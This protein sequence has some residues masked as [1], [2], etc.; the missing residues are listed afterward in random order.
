MGV[1]L[2]VGNA[3]S[4]WTAMARARG[5]AWVDGPG[6]LAVRADSAHRVLLAARPVADQAAL[7]SELLAVF[8]AWESRQLCIEDPTRSLDFT[9]LGFEAALT[10]PMMVREPGASETPS[11]RRR[12]AAVVDAQVS[13]GGAS[14]GAPAA[15]GVSVG[16]AVREED[17][18][19]VERVVV[20]GFPILP[21]LPWRR[22][23]QFPAHAAVPGQRSWLA[24]VDGRPAAACVTHDDGAAVGFY[25]VA[26]LPE[27]RSRGA[28]RAVMRAGLAAHADRPATL[29]ATLLGEPLY[30][31]LG[32]TERG[33]ARWW[34]FPATP[35]E[36]RR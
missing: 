29:T 31:R 1:E 9:D 19:A 8:R 26:T 16:E 35:E 4:H 15:D 18:A 10:M 20:E 33:L 3:A 6:F 21:R 2:A 12:A 7:R 30:R 14:A 25:W 34:Q 32:F 17:L 5:W 22:G 28:G 36:L 13:D 23:E 27:F 11:L 24:R